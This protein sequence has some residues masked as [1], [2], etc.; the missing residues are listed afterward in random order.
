MCFIFVFMV[1]EGGGRPICFPPSG[2][3]NDLYARG[4]DRE[5]ARV[6]GQKPTLPASLDI[7]AGHSKTLQFV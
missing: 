7:P 6:S 5:I 3:A 1:W 2:S 4:S